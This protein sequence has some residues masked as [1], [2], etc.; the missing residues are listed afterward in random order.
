MKVLAPSISSH[1]VESYDT[2]TSKYSSNNHDEPAQSTILKAI[3]NPLADTFLE[4]KSS[5][6][7][8]YRVFEVILVFP[9]D[10]II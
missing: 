6:K 9:K 2:V 10:I 1:P 4:L 8:L 3:S 5:A 7:V